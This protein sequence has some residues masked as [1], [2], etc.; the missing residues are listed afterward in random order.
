MIELIHGEAPP[1]LVL[2]VGDNFY[3]HGVMGRYDPLFEQVFENVY[4]SLFWEPLVFFP[5]LGN[6]DYDGSVID[7]MKY[8]ERNSRWSLTA[9]YYTFQKPLP[10][11]ESVRFLALDTQYIRSRGGRTEVRLEFIDSVLGVATDR[12]IVAYG[13]H[14]MATVGL[15]APDKPMLERV[16]PLLEGRVP[17]YLAGHN[18]SLELLPVSEKLLQGVCGGGGGRDNPYPVRPTSEAL[19]AFTHGG[20]CFLHFM[21][22]YLVL[23]LHNHGGVIQYRHIIPHPSSKAKWRKD[24][25]GG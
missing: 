23:D 3:P 14:P 9:Q 11:G 13:H 24:V 21:D 8:S 5:T 2:T 22:D 16:A 19:A 12:W 17:L 7:Q 15:H 18:H 6:H 10:S 4:S 1:D 20:W 25:V